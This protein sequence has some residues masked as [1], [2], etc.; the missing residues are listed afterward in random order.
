M[1]GNTNE[2]VERLREQTRYR[3]RLLVGQEAE[4]EKLL[5]DDPDHPLI[6]RESDRRETAKQVQ[7]LQ[8]LL[9]LCQPYITRIKSFV[10]K[11]SDETI[12]AASYLLFCQAAQHLD[13][14][15]ILGAEG[16]NFQASEVIRAI[17]R[18]QQAVDKRLNLIPV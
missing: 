10:P 8:G 11:I 17:A 2:I 18:I 1:P 15:L 7:Q 5:E 12:E 3:K 13:A 6:E 16:L 4:I 14:V 9:N